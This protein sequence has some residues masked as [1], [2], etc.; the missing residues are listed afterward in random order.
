MSIFS[1]DRPLFDN[2]SGFFP[3][4]TNGVLVIWSLRIIQINFVTLSYLVCKSL[5][6]GR[7]LKNL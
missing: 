3:R 4:Q 7:M 1:P 2:T 5:G 6:Y